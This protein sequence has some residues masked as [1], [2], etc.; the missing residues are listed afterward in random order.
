M[1]RFSMKPLFRK[2]GIW[3]Q[4][5]HNSHLGI[6]NT[7]R[8]ARACN[9]IKF[10]RQVKWRRAMYQSQFSAL[11]EENGPLTRPPIQI[12]DGWAID[13]SMSLPH[14][15][16][17]LDDSE[18]IISERAHSK[19]EAIAHVVTEFYFG[20]LPVKLRGLQDVQTGGVITRTVTTDFIEPAKI[21]R[22]EDP[23]WKKIDDPAQLAVVKP[24]IHLSYFDVYSE[25]AASGRRN[26]V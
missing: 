12:R 14:L 23:N 10:R 9:G 22:G 13:I 24:A 7:M 1:R 5:S 3:L 15:N 4:A 16:R 8:L 25:D 6:A 11:L 17:V 26:H 21:E 18:T 20:P 19:V 2:L